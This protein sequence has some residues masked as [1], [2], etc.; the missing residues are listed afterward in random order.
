MTAHAR[1]S[2]SVAIGPDGVAFSRVDDLRSEGPLVLRPTIAN[3]PEPLLRK[4]LRAARVALASGAA[5][6]LGGD[7]FTLS[8]TVGA[9]STLLLSEVSSTLLLPGARGG[10]SH[11]RISITVESGATFCWL[12]EPLVAAR[13]CHHVH[14][15]EVEVAPDATM[16][17]RDEL[18]LGRY[19]EEPGRLSQRLRV[20]CEGRSIF[21]QRLDLGAGARGWRSPAVLGGHKCVG[22]VLAV[23]P[24]LATGT[25]QPQLIGDAAALL[26]LSGSGVVVSA[27]ADDTV[28]LRR[29]LEEGIEL[30]GEPWTEGTAGSSDSTE[31]ER[32][33]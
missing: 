4:D 19:G 22:T 1:V 32:E 13:G 25:R 15:I 12:P 24:D 26:P 27:M 18:V 17:L 2:T 14:E 5:G 9:G 3:R 23:A 28:R 10:R 11:M 7:E 8:V 33:W 31:G 29:R 16:L 21:Q 6:P 20:A 30:L